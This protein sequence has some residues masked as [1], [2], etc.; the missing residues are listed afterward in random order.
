MNSG[1]TKA[2]AA[3]IAAAAAVGWLGYTAYSLGNRPERI[4]PSRVPSRDAQAEKG[5]RRVQHTLTA[6]GGN[7]A[8]ATPAT[9]RDWSA[10]TTPALAEATLSS[11]ATRLSQ[12]GAAPAGTSAMADKLG[13][14]VRTI[15]T[16]LLTGH[17]DQFRATLGT[18]GAAPPQ[19]PPA[20]AKPGGPPGGAAGN[21]MFKALNGAQLDL[22]HAKVRRLTP[23][24]AKAGP[25]G[26]RMR[27]PGGAGGGGGGGG[28][29][30]GGDFG[31][32]VAAG[33]R[34]AF[35]ESEKSLE[36][37]TAHVVEVTVPL[38]INGAT[39][40]DP[41]AKISFKMVYDKAADAWQPMMLALALK[42]P[43]ILKQF[44]PQGG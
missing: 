29:D 40:P 24:E 28:G 33:F 20:G 13:Q 39:D 43:A 7:A 36:A 8:P 6:G 23:E 44:A 21:P 31:A 22:A 25:G 9:P 19:D 26:R 10:T 12:E 4:A 27:G 14:N 35:P 41:N 34:G 37:G 16:P 42:D 1:K 3:I 32:V 11:L 18:L 2:S 15:L 38:L 30:D 5:E 17:S